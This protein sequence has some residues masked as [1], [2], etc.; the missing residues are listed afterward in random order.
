MKAKVR[1]LDRRGVGDLMQGQGSSDAWLVRFVRVVDS[2]SLSSSCPGAPWPTRDEVETEPSGGT[3][4]S[5]SGALDRRRGG[6]GV[7]AVWGEGPACP[8]SGRFR[9]SDF[10]RARLPLRNRTLIP[11]HPC[12]PW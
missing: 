12:R 3:A 6:R 4:G 5:G 7:M 11:R 10:G 1:T 9:R 2:A 8:V